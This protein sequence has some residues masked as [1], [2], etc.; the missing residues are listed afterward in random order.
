[1]ENNGIPNQDIT[2][3]SILQNNP[4]YS[5]FQARLQNS[6]AWIASQSDLNSWIRVKLPQYYTI[7]AIGT[8]GYNGFIKQYTLSYSDDGAN[9]SDY[10]DSGVVK[11]CWK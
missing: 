7:S 11:V 2:Q 5:G 6:G 10:T 4:Q 8:Q 9:W 3:S 1:M